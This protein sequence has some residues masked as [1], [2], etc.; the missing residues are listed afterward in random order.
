MLAGILV[1]DFVATG[2]DAWNLVASPFFALL[3]CP[4][5]LLPLVS[6][7]LVTIE[8]SC[9]SDRLEILISLRAE[10]VK[11]QVISSHSLVVFALLKFFLLF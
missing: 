7:I 3:R 6:I 4:Y 5:V 10:Q 8:L 2:E 9:R 1:Y 11:S